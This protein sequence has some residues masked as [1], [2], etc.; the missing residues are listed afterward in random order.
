MELGQAHSHALSRAVNVAGRQGWACLEADTL[1]MRWQYLQRLCSR[2]RWSRT[3][4]LARLKNAFFEFHSKCGGE[5]LLAITDYPDGDDAEAA[6]GQSDAGQPEVDNELEDGYPSSGD[7]EA[8]HPNL[9]GS[10]T[11]VSSL[12]FHDVPASSR[13]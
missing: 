13:L 1:H 6:A 3:P 9:D 11:P 10:I 2:S 8:P 5:S 12:V 7:A 4:R